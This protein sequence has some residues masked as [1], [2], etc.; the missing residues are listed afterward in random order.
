MIKVK[1][2][3]GGTTSLFLLLCIGNL[4]W[5]AE[6]QPPPGLCMNTTPHTTASLWCEGLGQ[7]CCTE[8]AT[9]KIFC[10]TTH[11]LH[12]LQLRTGFC[13]CL[14]QPCSTLVHYTIHDLIFAMLFVLHWVSHFIFCFS[15]L[16][17]WLFLFCRLLKISITSDFNIRYSLFILLSYT[18]IYIFWLSRLLNIC[19]VT[20][21]FRNTLD[22]GINRI[23]NKNES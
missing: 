8:K 21:T 19:F 22:F 13:R 12:D 23:N 11:C 5:A 1:V 6:S 18:A 2:S 20:W 7:I 9:S 4:S 17:F 14:F 10:D 3:G 15:F 16:D